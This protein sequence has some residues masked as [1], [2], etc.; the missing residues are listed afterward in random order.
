MN[1]LPPGDMNA[2]A[3]AMTAFLAAPGAAEA[4]AQR[5][6]GAVSRKFTVRAMTAAVLDLYAAA[7]AVNPPL[8][9]ARNLPA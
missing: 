8:S 2:L 6:K 4:R 9:I 1:L 3:Q 5:L 7:L